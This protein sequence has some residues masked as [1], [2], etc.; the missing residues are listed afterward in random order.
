METQFIGRAF[1]FGKNIDTDQIY[2]GRF[3]ELTREKDIARHAMEGADPEFVKQFKAGDIIVASTNFGCGSS[4]EHA[5]ITLKAVG[6]AC[7]IAESFGRIFYRNA[8]NLGLPVLVCPGVSQHI[9]KGDELS[10]NIETGL[11]K[12]LTTGKDLHAQPLTGY[13]LKILSAGGIKTLIREKR[14]QRH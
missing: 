11:I 7:I 3:V 8:V 4:R 9:D 5:A 2:P 14:T 12:D 13:P 10:V 6:T 1:T